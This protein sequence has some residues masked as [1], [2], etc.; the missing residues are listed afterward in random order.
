MTAEHLYA[1]IAKR[2]NPLKGFEKVLGRKVNKCGDCKHTVPNEEYPDS[3]VDCRL[4][5][6]FYNIVRHKCK[7]FRG[8]SDK[9]KAEIKLKDSEI[10]ETKIDTH[11]TFS[12]PNPFFHNNHICP[13]CNREVKKKDV[14]GRCR[15]QVGKQYQWYHK[16]CKDS[17][18]INPIG[19]ENIKLK[20]ML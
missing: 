2:D 7:R 20:L 14:K 4:Y 6:T 13:F 17:N 9:T 1:I 5:K 11:P 16:K 12:I 8:L 3:L 10:A 18:R 19:F 15:L